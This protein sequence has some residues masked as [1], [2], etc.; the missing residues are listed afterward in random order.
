M[1]TEESTSE[2]PDLLHQTPFTSQLGTESTDNKLNIPMN[3]SG[4]PIDSPVKQQ[5]TESSY[6]ISPP[7]E[8]NPIEFEETNGFQTPA[9]DTFPTFENEIKYAEDDS[10]MW[11]YSDFANRD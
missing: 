1:E 11:G 7:S 4:I 8:E 5:K 6:Q 10:E 9:V 2:Q 3:F